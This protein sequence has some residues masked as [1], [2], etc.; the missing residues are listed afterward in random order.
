M[1]SKPRIKS[2]LAKKPRTTSAPTKAAPPSEPATVAPT[3]SALVVPS[4]RVDDAPGKSPVDK[5]TRALHYAATG[6]L[7]RYARAPQSEPK[8]ESCEVDGHRWVD[9]GRGVRCVR[10]DLP[11]R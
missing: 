9:N 1:P 2:G 6:Q 11:P 3:R 4:P 8:R 10:C 7:R 5:M